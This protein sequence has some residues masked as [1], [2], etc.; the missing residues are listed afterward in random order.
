MTAP[1]SVILCEGY[2]DRSFLAGALLGK[3]GW[4]EPAIDARGRRLPHRDRWQSVA[5][6]DYGFS[7]PSGA[8]LRLRPCHGHSKIPAVARTILRE[9]ATRPFDRLILNCDGDKCGSGCTKT[10]DCPSPSTQ[11]CAAN[12][13]CLDRLPDGSACDTK[14]TNLVPTDAACLSN[15]CRRDSTAG[16]NR[17]FCAP[18]GQCV[19][20]L[21]NGYVA[22]VPSGYKL[23][24]SDEKLPNNLGI[25]VYTCG[26]GGVWSVSGCAVS[27][28][29]GYKG[30][31]DPGPTGYHAGVQ[32]VICSSGSSDIDG[33]KLSKC[34]ECGHY[35][36]KDGALELCNGASC[37]DGTSDRQELC[38]GKYDIC[39]DSACVPTY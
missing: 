4:T 14:L 36:Q 35:Y 24:A 5:G 9:R 22:F 30:C 16:N 33:C 2:H 7:H 20:E 38:R 13:L 12:G 32:S 23:C 6:G 3:L 28:I 21:S 26:N 18:A 34:L 11:F 27:T 39:I 8:Q 31:G 29:S 17:W 1:F 37:N 15:A 19:K 10:S 25:K